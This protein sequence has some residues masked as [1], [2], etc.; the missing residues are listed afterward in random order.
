MIFNFNMLQT[1]F[2]LSLVKRGDDLLSTTT[3]IICG[4]NLQPKFKSFIIY[5]VM[6]VDL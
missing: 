6:W 5:Y 4:Q 3:W 2:L 1:R